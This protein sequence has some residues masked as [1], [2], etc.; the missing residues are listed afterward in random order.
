MGASVGAS[1]GQALLARPSSHQ[2]LCHNTLRCMDGSGLQH[3][4]QSAR[5]AVSQAAAA[6]AAPQGSTG[7]STLPVVIETKGVPV[8]Y[9]GLCCVLACCSR[10]PEQAC[11]AV[12]ILLYAK[13]EEVEVEALA[14]LRKLA[15]SP[16]PVSTASY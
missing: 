2:Q 16:L 10:V 7:S 14:Q 8:S 3:R 4:V 1:V 13:Q 9:G 15:E 11:T 12:Q 5:T 6:E